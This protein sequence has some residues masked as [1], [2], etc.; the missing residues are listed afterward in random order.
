MKTQTIKFAEYEGSQDFSATCGG[1]TIYFDSYN[2]S[3]EQSDNSPLNL[4]YNGV[5]VGKLSN[6]QAK[7]FYHWLGE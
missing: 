1:I 4:F 7:S 2:W 3:N 5:L 6:E